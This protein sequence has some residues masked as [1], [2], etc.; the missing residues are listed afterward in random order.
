MLLFQIFVNKRIGALLK[1]IGVEYTVTR[2]K[3]KSGF[4]VYRYAF[5]VTE[6]QQQD[7]IAKLFQ[8]INFSP[9]LFNFQIFTKEEYKNKNWKIEI[10]RF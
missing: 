6:E 1:R 5:L 4:E 8:D 2:H 9:K 10:V 3:T 7:I